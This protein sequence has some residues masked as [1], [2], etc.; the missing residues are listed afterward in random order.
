MKA[1]ASLYVIAEY[2]RT[3]VMASYIV[4]FIEESDGAAVFLAK[5]C[6]SIARSRR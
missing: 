4:A 6:G 1:S 2:P 5:A 3:P